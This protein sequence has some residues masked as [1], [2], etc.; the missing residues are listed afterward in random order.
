MPFDIRK[1]DE[2][3]DVRSFLDLFEANDM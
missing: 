1:T 2:P 3:S